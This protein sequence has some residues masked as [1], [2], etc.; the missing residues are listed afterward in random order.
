[1]SDYPTTVSRPIPLERVI[2][3]ATRCSIPDDAPIWMMGPP[4]PLDV[5]KT[6]L[7]PGVFMTDFHRRRAAR[8]IDGSGK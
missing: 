3:D 6:P 4:K 7:E 8:A 5:R 2:V 1:M